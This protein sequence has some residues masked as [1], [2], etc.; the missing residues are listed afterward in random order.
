[1][2]EELEA[3][4]RNKTWKLTKLPEKKKAINFRWVFKVKLKPD[5]SIGKQKARLLARGFL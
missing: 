2:K 5:G 3:I 1:M 4:E